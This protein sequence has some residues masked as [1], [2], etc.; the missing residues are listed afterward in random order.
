MGMFDY[1]QYKDNHYQTKSLDNRL[2]NY[3]LEDGYLWKDQ[4]EQVWVEDNSRFGGYLEKRGTKWVK[5]V[6]FSGTIEF[7]RNLDKT[8]K[9]WEENAAIILDGAIMQLVENCGENTTG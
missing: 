3:K 6:T 8:Y 2:C 5:Q 7:H 4:A 1:I 9:T